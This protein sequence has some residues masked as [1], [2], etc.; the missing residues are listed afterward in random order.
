M[1]SLDISCS[2]IGTVG[3]GVMS[4]PNPLHVLQKD[5]LAAAVVELG[6][7]AVGVAG[8]SPSGFKGA[9]VLEKICDTGRPE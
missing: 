3:K 1:D 2:L 6:G 7:P 4:I 8:D 5:L 9:V